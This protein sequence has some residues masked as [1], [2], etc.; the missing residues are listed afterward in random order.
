MAYW[1]S[2]VKLLGILGRAQRM[3]VKCITEPR[4]RQLNRAVLDPEIRP[5]LTNCCSA[6]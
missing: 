3:V 1:N 4:F 6:R 5:L 2:Y